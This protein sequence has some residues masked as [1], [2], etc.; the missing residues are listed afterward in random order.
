MTDIVQ[1]EDWVGV[2]L[3]EP[4]RDFL[5]KHHESIFVGDRVLLYGRSDLRER[6]EVCGAKEYCP[7]YVVIGDD[8]GDWRFLLPL[9][10]G[11]LTIVDAGAM[12]PAWAHPLANNFE[13]WL[14]AGCPLPEDGD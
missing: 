9:T 2:S 4:Y 12:S 6:N 10:G 8:S 1:I 11:P 7:G 14:E 5:S 13:F 3:P